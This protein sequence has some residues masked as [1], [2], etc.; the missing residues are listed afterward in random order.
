[1]HETSLAGRR[2]VRELRTRQDG[3]QAARRPAPGRARLPR[4]H[5]FVRE[6]GGGGGGNARLGAHRPHRRRAARRE[7]AQ[8]LDRRAP[9]GYRERLASRAWGP[10]PEGVVIGHVSPMSRL[11]CRTCRDSRHWRARREVSALCQRS[12]STVW[13]RSW[14]SFVP[15]DPVRLA[16]QVAACRRRGDP[17]FAT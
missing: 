11:M 3:R 9:R 12:T 8:A 5:E 13:R 14:R 16:R 1:M 15:P 2:P 7:P 4:Y 6:S 17:F 10:E